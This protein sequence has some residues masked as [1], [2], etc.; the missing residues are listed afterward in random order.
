MPEAF[1]YVYLYAD[2]VMRAYEYSRTEENSSN[3][4]VQHAIRSGA[5]L[6]A[7]AYALIAV[8]ETETAKQICQEQNQLICCMLKEEYDAAQAIIR[9]IPDVPDEKNA[10]AYTSALYLKEIYQAILS[11]DE[12]AFE[13]AML[14]RIKKYRR[15]TYEYSLIL[16]TCG[17]MMVK[18][19]RKRG[20]DFY[21]NV[22]E[23]PQYF[24]DETVHADKK[25]YQLP[26]IRCR[27]IRA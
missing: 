21:Y 17:T 3:A 10:V 16:D 19:A 23:I 6:N 26:E 8:N 22:A 12:T 4:A 25:Q 2:S 11:G 27:E 7:L 20:L 24:L 14:T 13:T 1:G 18:F 5:D 9:E 15:Y